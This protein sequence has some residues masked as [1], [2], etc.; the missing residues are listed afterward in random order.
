MIWNTASGISIE[1][2][3][4]VGLLLDPL[5]FTTIAG[6]NRHQPSLML[7]Q[8]LLWFFLGPDVTPPFRTKEGKREDR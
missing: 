8:N 3:R 7:V 5:L 4:G 6:Y 2:G 1:Q